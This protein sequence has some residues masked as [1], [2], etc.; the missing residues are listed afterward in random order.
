MR[1]LLV[2]VAS[3]GTAAAD[4]RPLAFVDVEGRIGVAGLTCLN[5]PGG[6]PSMSSRTGVAGVGTGGGVFVTPDLALVGR[7]QLGTE[8]P[9]LAAFA[10]VGLQLRLAPMDEPGRYMFCE[11]EVGYGGVGTLIGGG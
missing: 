1:S 11:T 7:A 10:G 2:V 9:K 5:A 8:E 3:I 4:P 6:E